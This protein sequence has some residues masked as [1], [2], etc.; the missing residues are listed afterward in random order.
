MPRIGLSIARYNENIDWL[1]DLQNTIQNI[2]IYIM[3]KGNNNIP[4]Q[5]QTNITSL[6]NIGKDQH[7]HLTY[8]INNYDNLPDIVI[9][10]QA[11]I[12]DHKDV[13]YS[14][15]YPKIHIINQ[16]PPYSQT[17]SPTEIIN[18]MITQV[19]LNGHTWNERFYLHPDG[20][21][22]TLPTLKVTSTHP[23]E[24]DS[25]MSFGEWFE[26]NVQTPFPQNNQ[27]FW[28]KNSI[29]GV[30]KHY[31]LSKPKSYYK[32]LL[33]QIHSNNAEILHYI[34]RSW[35]Y[36]LN[37]DK[38]HMPFT[39]NS[40]L[41]SHA[42]IFDILHNII[43]DSGQTLVEGS[44]FFKGAHDLSPT[45]EF[46]HKQYNIF[47]LAKDAKYILEIGF[48][49]GHSTALM[50]MANPN[51]KILHFDL[52]EHKYTP[53]CYEFLKSVFGEHRFISLVKGDSTKTIPDF[54]QSTPIEFDLIH[55]DGGHTEEI[56]LQDITNCI[57]AANI[58]NH[59]LIIDD[60][61]M[62]HLKTVINDLQSQDIIIPYNG[63]TPL[64][65]YNGEY[66][67]FIGHYQTLC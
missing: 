53:S 32:M 16:S 52:W 50:L 66:Y 59:T 30:Q 39:F 8:I 65:D 3:N 19:Q 20:K 7:S 63:N 33:N 13:F 21:P 17:L 25:T 23:E 12:E 6:P 45:P 29:F 37:L 55:I 1:Q 35:F 42:F 56:L 62:P 47:N 10:T 43:L 9:F 48:N 11:N 60:Y 15:P 67:H 14:Q 49:A 64:V 26:K 22:C 44:L 41:S 54:I 18:H 58:N 40:T 38:Y 57:E 5:L 24:E 31:I 28:F 46:I 61:N 36:I 51:S 34:E 4:H 27:V 2:D